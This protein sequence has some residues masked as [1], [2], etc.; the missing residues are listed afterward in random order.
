[1]SKEEKVTH[2]LYILIMLYHLSYLEYVSFFFCI[3]DPRVHFMQGC[4]PHHQQQQQRY[5]RTISKNTCFFLEGTIYIKSDNRFSL[6]MFLV[7]SLNM[8]VEIML[9]ISSYIYNITLNIIYLWVF[10]P[11]HSVRIQPHGVHGILDSIIYYGNAL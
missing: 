8:M 6:F 2:H 10:I 4:L 3:F 7:G 9:P 1:M 5:L 11:I